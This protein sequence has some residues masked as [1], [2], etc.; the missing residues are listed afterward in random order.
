MTAD[1]A[2]PTHAPTVV[3]PSANAV[4]PQEDWGEIRRVFRDMV[5]RG[6]SEAQIDAA[7]L[8]CKATGFN[9]ILQHINLIDGKVYVT[10]KG[11]W[12]L[13]HRSKMLNGIEILEQ[14]E[15]A[16]HYTAR[17]SIFR[18]DM[19]HP[20]TFNG[21]YP[22]TGRNK[23]YGEEMA[24]ARAECMALRRAFDVSMPIYEEINWSEREQQQ[25]T[26]LGATTIIEQTAT[27][28]PDTPPTLPLTAPG[29]VPGA[30]PLTPNERAKNLLAYLR[31][32]EHPLE[33]Q[34]EACRSLFALSGT[35][36]TLQRL[37]NA[38]LKL[39]HQD[40]VDAAWYAR[41]GELE[42]QETTI[43]EVAAPEEEQQ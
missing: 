18:K 31:E 35:R 5:G 17:V 36:D 37:Y 42:Q 26:N 14:G 30:A 20:F 16:T 12:N 24:L 11:L 39:C 22:K 3:Q 34:E 43:I 23:Q 41:L 25:H 29:E 7:I 13:A 38:A 15:N 28:N 27:P 40:A 8:V 21:R 6:I 10:H 19:D 32:D 9:P 2:R 33:E 4:Q 1:P